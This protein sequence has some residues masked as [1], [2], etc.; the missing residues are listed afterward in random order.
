MSVSAAQAEAVSVALRRELIAYLESGETDEAARGRLLTLPGG[1]V[2][3][4]R[5]LFL[6]AARAAFPRGEASVDDFL[7]EKQA[8][9]E[10]E[11]ERERDARY[12]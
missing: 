2:A 8:E 10:V 12:A 5:A 4:E 6:R 11:A 1:A 3:L 7:Q 9:R